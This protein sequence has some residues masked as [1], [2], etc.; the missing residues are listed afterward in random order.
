LQL[1]SKQVRAIQCDGTQAA[2]L[3][4]PGCV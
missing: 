1:S 2:V 3:E 4:E